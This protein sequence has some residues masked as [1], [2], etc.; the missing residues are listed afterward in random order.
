MTL[1]TVEQMASRLQG[2]IATG[3]YERAEAALND[4]SALVL[5]LVDDDTRTRW[6]TDPPT[7]VV[8]VVCQAA[9]R[10][11]MNPHG[12]RSERQG[13][14]QYELESATGIILTDD[15]R[16][17]VNRA[18]GRTDVRAIETTHPYGFHYIPSYRQAP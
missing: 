10:G 7:A 2:G 15:E 18:A 1:A 3:D 6:E 11:F 8:A 12:I 5:D 16:R 13:D 14:Y 4:A 9:I 17:T